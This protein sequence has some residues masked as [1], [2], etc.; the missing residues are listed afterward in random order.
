MPS[1]PKN[2][3]ATLLAKQAA[4]EIPMSAGEEAVHEEAETPQEEALEHLPGQYEEGAVEPGELEG[5]EDADARVEQLLAQL[6]PEEL[7]HLT[8][9]LAED[10]SGGEEPAAEIDEE[11]SVEDPAELAQLIEQHLA[12]SPEAN[13]ED[14]DPEKMAALAFVKSASYIEGFIEQ[15]LAHGASV[16][17]AV[18]IYDTALSRSLD[19]LNI[20]KTAARGKY[21]R[22]RANASRRASA[23]QA[24]PSA[25]SKA[26]EAAPTKKPDYEGPSMG[27]KIKH[28]LEDHPETAVA[29]G[30][31]AAATAAGGAYL[32]T[33][34]NKDKEDSDEKTAAYYEGVLERARE[35]GLSDHEAVQIVK[36]ATL[37]QMRNPKVVAA[38]RA[39]ASSASSAAKK[40]PKGEA[41]KL[42][43]R[44]RI[45]AIK[46]KAL[47]AG[48]AGL[49]GGAALTSALSDD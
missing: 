5:G 30:A 17:E 42:L 37:G 32:A 24:A 29:L 34:K 10:M 33:R 16:K 35:Y 40:A 18:D 12:N 11:E 9:L 25:A 43:Q 36:S 15:A 31:G 41:D 14:A 19:S 23:P 1:N 8:E 22:R 39:A 28:H 27:S 44:A 3:L 7:D 6:S 2:I 20:Y 13:P 4:G 45:A 21:A 49:A 48:G 26:Q 38:L 46:N 47:I